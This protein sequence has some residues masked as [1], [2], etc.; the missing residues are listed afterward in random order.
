MEDANAARDLSYLNAVPE[1][2]ELNPLQL[3]QRESERISQSRRDAGNLIH[4]RT[5]AVREAQPISLTAVAGF[6]LVAVLALSVLS[7]HIRLNGVYT[8]TVAQ[9]KQLVQLEEEFSKLKATNEAIFD[10]ESL[11]KVAEEAGLVKPS[12]NQ[13]VYL[14]MSPPN[15]TVVYAKPDSAS[16]ISGVLQ[17]FKGLLGL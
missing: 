10:S 5:S 6:L 9:Q 1:R 2:E 16:G 4:E 12:V 8:Q 14:K 13:Q 3:P 15:N 11:Q 7:Y 17:W